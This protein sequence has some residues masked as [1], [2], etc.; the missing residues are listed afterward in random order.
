MAISKVIFNGVTQMDVTQKTVTSASMLN[1][2]TALKNDGT[3]ITGDITN[4]TL[5]SSTSASSSG[6]SKAT[7]T[8]TSSAQ[9]LNIPIGYNDTAQY[10]TIGASSGGGGN[11]FIVT[12]SKNNNDEWI[13]NCT[14]SEL[15]NAYN[16]NKNISVNIDENLIENCITADGSVYEEQGGV[17]TLYG[18]INE[19]F[20]EEES[21]YNS[22]VNIHEVIWNNNGFSVSIPYPNYETINGNALPADVVSGKIFFN[23]AGKQVGTLSNG[24]SFLVEITY[25]NEEE[26]W[27]PNKT[28][29]EIYTAYSNDKEIYA[30]VDS[31]DAMRGVTVSSYFNNL[32]GIYY[33][34]IYEPE[35]GVVNGDITI[36]E[37]RLD[38]DVNNND[39]ITLVNDDVYIYPNFQTKTVSYTP[40]ASQQTATITADNNYNGLQQV[41]VT[42]NAMPAGTAGTPTATKGTVNNHAVTITPSVTNTTGYITGGTLTGT[43]VSVSASELVSGSQ[44]ITTNNTY[45]V[46]NLSQ[47]VVNVPSG[48]SSNLVTGEFTVPAYSS[49]STRGEVSIPYNGSGYPI[50]GMIYVKNGVYNGTGASTWYNGIKR[51]AVGFLAFSK[52]DTT[53]APTFTSSDNDN[54]SVMAIYKNS[55]SAANNYTRNSVMSSNFFSTSNPPN[56][57]AICINFRND[58]NT[59]RYSIGNGSASTYGLYP[60]VTYVYHII[61]SSPA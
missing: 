38:L 9:Y 55:T 51:Y 1:G 15:C 58:V 33:Y 53:T 19:Y 47:V 12:L 27:I 35:N 60:E 52:S 5:P 41:N 56:T 25:D 54:C 39:R 8:P 4:M 11:D 48:G 34:N 20:Y 31:Y 57:S 18:F 37:Y 46:T 2:A 21:P 50:A 42:V 7:I 28:F 16:S 26:M 23:S 49:S 14:Y 22:G 44:N 40:S 61:Y 10:Y 45:D 29:A 13:P 59:M 32:M 3:D 30:C 43:G 36:Y 17:I 6:T 24:N